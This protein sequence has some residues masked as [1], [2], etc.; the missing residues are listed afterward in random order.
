MFRRIC[1][2]TLLV[3]SC[4][5]LEI[6]TSI[7]SEWPALEHAQKVTCQDLTPPLW[8]ASL[9]TVKPLNQSIK[10]GAYVEAISR[11]NQRLFTVA[12][13]LHLPS[14][15]ESWLPLSEEMQYLGHTEGRLFFSIHSLNPE[16][17]AETLTHLAYWDI[18]TKKWTKGQDIFYDITLTNWIGAIETS[19]WIFMDGEMGSEIVT[20]DISTEP[21]SAIRR[22]P[23]QGMIHTAAIWQDHQNIMALMQREVFHRPPPQDLPLPSF[24]EGEQSPFAIQSEFSTEESIEDSFL[25]GTEE[26]TI[27]SPEELVVSETEVD[28]DSYESEIFILNLSAETTHFEPHK[29]LRV[30]AGIEQLRAL[31]TTT[32]F[33]LAYIQG[34]SLVGE[35]TLHTA[36]LTQD[37]EGVWKLINTKALSLDLHLG[38]PYLIRTTGETELWMLHWVDFEPSLA[39]MSFSKIDSREKISYHGVF[40][41]GS[42]IVGAFT[43][44]QPIQIVLRQKELLHWSFSRCQL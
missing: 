1:F 5:T 14:Q 34:D 11:N 10:Q 7:L 6:G 8:V 24:E 39:R 38:P 9:R 20:F 17:E 29:I 30:P 43:Q 3:G 26:G 36:L 35:G 16:N 2:C 18:A 21:F 40:R 4:T 25:F 33:K 42:V 22:T 12:P 13:Y 23:T 19:M 31:R 27:E 28:E 32:G 15:P 44:S 41:P 37:T